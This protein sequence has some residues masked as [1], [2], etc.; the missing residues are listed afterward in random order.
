MTPEQCTIGLRVRVI[1]APERQG[2][3]ATEPYPIEGGWS[4]RVDFYGGGRLRTRLDRLEPLPDYLDALSEIEGGRFQGPE[5][6]RRN[7]L[8]EKL[9]GR[10]SDVMYSMETSDI[11]FLPYQFKPILKLLESP[12]N[13]LLIADEVGLGKTIEAGLIWTELK[14]R[15]GARTLLVVC[16]PHL[17][18]KWRSELKRRFGVDAQ[19]ADASVVSEKLDE[20]R[21]NQT[22]GFALVA[23]YHGLRPPKGWEDEN[24]GPASQL[25]RK[26]SE[27]SAAEEPFLD[28][29]IMD[30][31]A[32]MRNEPSQTSKDCSPRLPDTRFTCPRPRSTRK[33]EI[34]SPYCAASTRTRFQTSKLLPVS[35]R[36]TRLWSRCGSPSL[37]G[38]LCGNPCW[39]NWISPFTHPCFRATAPLLT[40]ERASAQ[41]P[42]SPTQRCA[43][44]SLIKA[45]APICSPTS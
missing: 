16:P 29:L 13:S 39:L 7:L 45:S 12:T 36:P 28:L 40:Y 20:A 9:H 44:N 23:T 11:N 5:S 10:L 15:E 32:I 25:A 34:S 8:H 3:I 4:V 19:D 21:R 26:L 27:W 41:K 2:S 38:R 37:L 22:S 1:G 31:A 42:I 17:V 30:E 18:T 6:L 43:P 14:A 33:R 24:N 35:W